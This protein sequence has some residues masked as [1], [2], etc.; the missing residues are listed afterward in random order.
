M[1]VDDLLA[2]RAPYEAA[3]EVAR[4][5]YVVASSQLAELQNR[6]M[7]LRRVVDSLTTLTR[8]TAT[9]SATREKA[10]HLA[11]AILRHATVAEVER[12]N[13]TLAAWVNTDA[14][15]D[16]P[17]RKAGMTE[18]LMTVMS[19]F[20]KPVDRE[21]VVAA[22]EERALISPVY[23]RTEAAIHQALYRASR[24]GHLERRGENYAL[25]GRFPPPR[26]LVSRP[27]TDAATKREEGAAG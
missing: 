11:D 9:R 4:K 10:G 20:Q 1:D 27:S 12:G 14:P 6:V 24:D 15:G 13:A 7:T 5:E 2:S 23:D 25:P 17:S 22:F 3:L 8:P 19:S 26:R 16:E 18:A 21:R